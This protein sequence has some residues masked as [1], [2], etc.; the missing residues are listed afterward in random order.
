[1][2]GRL[3]LLV[4]VVVSWVASA[5]CLLEASRLSGQQQSQAPTFKAASI[6]VQVDA[7]VFDK[8]GHLVGRQR[9]GAG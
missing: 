5:L 2:R 9:Y 7:Y 3:A 6:Y 8:R 1:M 4:L